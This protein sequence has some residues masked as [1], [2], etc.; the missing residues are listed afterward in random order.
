L[1]LDDLADEV[2]LPHL[3]YLEEMPDELE[4]DWDKKD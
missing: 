2:G 4:I 1:T 3:P